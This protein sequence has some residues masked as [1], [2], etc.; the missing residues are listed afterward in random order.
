MDSIGC[1]TKLRWRG[2][3]LVM[4]MMPLFGVGRRSVRGH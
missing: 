3:A 4:A 2:V 1:I